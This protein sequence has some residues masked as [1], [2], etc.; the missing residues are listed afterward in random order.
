MI[1]FLPSF[2][3]LHLDFM[4]QMNNWK[5]DSCYFYYREELDTF[6]PK[7]VSLELLNLKPG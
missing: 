3:Y 2:D 7:K 4:N 1:I 6:L 5:E